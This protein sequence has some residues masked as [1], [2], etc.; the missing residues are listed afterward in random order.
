DDPNQDD[1]FRWFGEGFD[2]FPKRLPDDCVEYIIHVIDAELQNAN[3]LRTRL[4]DILKATSKLKKDILKDYIWQRDSFELV[5]KSTA[6]SETSD[7]SGRDLNA[8]RLHLRGRTNFG[9]SISD[10]WLIVYVLRELSK[11]FLDAWIRVY[12]TDGEF[13]LI[14]AAAALPKWLNPDVAEN[15]VWLN[16]GHIKLIPLQDGPSSRNLGITD[17]ANFIETRKEDM[18]ISPYLED[19]AFRRLR[20]YPAAIAES[21]HHAKVSIPR[22]LAY[23]LRRNPAYISPAIESF[24][25]RDPISV[26]PLTTKDTS[27]LNFPP[28]DFITTSVRFTKVSYA[29]ILSQVFNPPPAWTGVAPR[30][31]DPKVD[32]GM[33][34]TCGFEMLLCDPQSKAKRTV[35]EMKLLLEDLEAGEEKLPSDSEIALWPQQEDDEKWLDI[36]YAEFEDELAGKKGEQSSDSKD[37]K[38]FG[39]KG[40]QENLK[41][42]VSRFEDFLKDDEI[43]VA[44]VDDEVED[45]NDD[46]SDS[47]SGPDEEETSKVDLKPAHESNAYSG[48]EFKKIIDEVRDLHPDFIEKSGL[49]DEARKLALDDEEIDDEDDEL[50]EDEEMKKIMEIMEQELNGYG[51]LDL[52]DGRYKRTKP[53]QSQSKLDPSNENHATTKHYFGPERPPHMQQDALVRPGKGKAR[54]QDVD[55]EFGPGDGELSSD[56]DDFNDVDLGLAK[57][58]LESFKGQAGLAGPAGNLMRAMGVNMPRDE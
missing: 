35:L 18:I 7:S 10:E 52:K 56:D 33:K 27:T 43:G 24:Y 36:D 37:S 30:I 23:I 32:K 8:L 48:S 53:A 20:G 58:M 26:K 39:D 28:E 38:G 5:I 13:L 17:A 50:N 42:M 51:A 4:N 57:N 46:E 15:R 14:E 3:T 29:Q 44:G 31:Q 1:G 34:L 41:R 45:E 11:Q 22:R 9:D 6:A 40:A 47:E 12:D 19:E 49:L 21:M 16:N 25:L 54:V 55:E 2:G